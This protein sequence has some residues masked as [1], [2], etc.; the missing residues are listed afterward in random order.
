[1]KLT[2]LLNPNA[3]FQFFRYEV[4]IFLW[5]NEYVASAF[6]FNISNNHNFYFEKGQKTIVNI[7]FYWEFRRLDWSNLIKIFVYV[8]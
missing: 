6:G 3:I 7:S 4:G 5:N 8:Y 2:T 1:M